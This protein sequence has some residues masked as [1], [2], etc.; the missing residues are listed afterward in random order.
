MLSG[1]TVVPTVYIDYK[2]KIHAR[3]LIRTSGHILE[4]PW[5]HPDAVCPSMFTAFA[6]AMA[7]VQKVRV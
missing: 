7:Q 6:I 5:L 3:R 1:I 4:S 2:C